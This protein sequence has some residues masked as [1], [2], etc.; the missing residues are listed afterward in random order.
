MESRARTYRRAQPKQASARLCE[1]T[2]RRSIVARFVL[3]LRL[4]VP[5]QNG[6]H[7]SRRHDR[8]GFAFTGRVVEFH[9]EAMRTLTRDGW[10]ACIVC[11]GIIALAFECVR[12]GSE[13]GPPAPFC[14]R[15]VPTFFVPR[16]S[17]YTL[18]FTS[19]GPFDKTTFPPNCSNCSFTRSMNS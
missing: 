2:R 14:T 13:V 10:L 4:G 6:S 1:R 8:A 11:E 17:T 7:A 5:N 16:R 12:M 19:R 18:Y 3:S 9:Q 15:P